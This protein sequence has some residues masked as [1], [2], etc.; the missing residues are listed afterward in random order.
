VPPDRGYEVLEHT[1]DVGL[2]V[3][4]PDLS[5]VFEQ[6][7]LGL[8]AIMGQGSG[9]ATRREEISLDAPDDIAL[10]VDW[11]SEV[12][13]LFDA[14]GFVPRAIDATVTSGRVRAVIDGSDAESFEQA[15]P[16]VKAVTYHDALVRRTPERYE[17]RVYL[18]V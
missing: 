4:G 10:L 11:L 8:I 18:D 17:A 5:A 6:A 7:A 15:G 1:A 13:F 12:L 16:A 9:P 14:R 2:R 3:W